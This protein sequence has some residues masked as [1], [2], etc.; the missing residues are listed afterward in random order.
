MTSVAETATNNSQH[1]GNTVE[2]PN[3]VFSNGGRLFVAN[4]NN[5]SST[6]GDNSNI[7]DDNNEQSVLLGILE[8]LGQ[9]GQFKSRSGFRKSFCFGGGV[10]C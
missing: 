1:G 2:S 8:S 3:D 7:D 9:V 5:A 4:N 10:I 6:P